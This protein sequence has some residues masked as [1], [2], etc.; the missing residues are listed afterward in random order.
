VTLHQTKQ[1]RFE[2]RTGFVIDRDGEIR[3]HD[4]FHP[5][6]ARY[7]AALRPVVLS[8]YCRRLFMSNRNSVFADVFFGLRRL[9]GFEHFPEFEKL[10]R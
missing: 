5:K 3:T 1:S 2:I 8:D 6:E 7:Q 10:R 4:L 9:V